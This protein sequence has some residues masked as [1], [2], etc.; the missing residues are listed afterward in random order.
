[1]TDG[2]QVCECAYCGRIGTAHVTRRPD[3]RAVRGFVC[4][5]GLLLPSGRLRALCAKCVEAGVAA[6]ARRAPRELGVVS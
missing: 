1:M 4:L 2:Q 3:T 5:G 6:F